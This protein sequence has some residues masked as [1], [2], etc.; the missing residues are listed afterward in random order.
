M[1]NDDLKWSAMVNLKSLTFHK[2]IILNDIL[3]NSPSHRTQPQTNNDLHVH[4]FTNFVF[5]FEDTHWNWTAIERDTKTIQHNKTMEEP[6]N[7]YLITQDMDIPEWALS[8]QRT[9]LKQE[10]NSNKN[11]VLLSFE[12]I[13]VCDTPKTKEMNARRKSRGKWAVCLCRR[14]RIS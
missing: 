6:I 9:V 8:M 2:T 12:C 4:F 3:L 7:F 1:T 14:A 10:G 5:C 11:A 13:R